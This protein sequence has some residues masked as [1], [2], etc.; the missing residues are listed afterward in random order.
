MVVF[1]DRRAIAWLVTYLAATVLAS[2][3][4]LSRE[5]HPSF[6]LSD[7][8]TQGIINLTIVDAFVFLV[9]Y[10]YVR[11]RAL[12][13]RQSDTLLRNVLPDSV[14]DRLKASAATIA[15]RFD[16]ATILFADVADF[17]PLAAGLSPEALVALLDEVFSE[18]DR[19]VEERGL[20]KIKTIGDAYM[21][22][23]GVPE[24]RPDHAHAVC[25]LALE[26]M[27]LV[28]GRDFDGQRIRLRMGISSGEVVA[29]VI[30]TKKFSY[31]LWGDTGT[32]PAAWR[33]EA[34]QAGSRSP[35]PPGG[36]SSPSSYATVEVKGKGPMQVWFLL[37]RA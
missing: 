10:Y 25:D 13:L 5:P 8:E 37:G 24:P 2:I 4:G 31:D 26:M 23:G 35:I 36:W 9:L 32:R 18:F 27:G 21:V 3:W 12:L 30:G 20:E 15:E 14:A 11:Q 17:T 29:G 1:A 22:A 19:L 34:S 7:S 6:S 28:E 16:S 33:R